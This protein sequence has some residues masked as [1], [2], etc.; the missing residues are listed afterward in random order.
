MLVRITSALRL[1]TKSSKCDRT[2][3]F[4]SSVVRLVAIESPPRALGGLVPGQRCEESQNRSPAAGGGLFLARPGGH[5]LELRQ[6]TGDWSAHL[7]EEVLGAD[8]DSPA[9]ALRLG[10]MSASTVPACRVSRGVLPAF[11][12]KARRCAVAVGVVAGAR[13]V[14]V[15]QRH[16]HR[17]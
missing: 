14:V 5:L 3:S 8:L 12:E 4:I 15:A 7:T 13:V 9:G 11:G 16:V 6:T 2:F 17:E 10:G 1:L